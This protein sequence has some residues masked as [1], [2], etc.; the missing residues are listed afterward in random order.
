MNIFG[1]DESE[2]SFDRYD[3]SNCFSDDQKKSV[4]FKL[5]A[6]HKDVIESN[7]QRFHYFIMLALT[8][9][10]GLTPSRISGLK[11]SHTVIQSVYF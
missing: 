2:P 9:N 6:D 11:V 5:P 7:R 8:G 1:F 3:I 4:S 10:L